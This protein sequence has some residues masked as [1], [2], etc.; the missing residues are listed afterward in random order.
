VYAFSHSL[1]T[2]AAFNL[3]MGAIF[4]GVNLSLF[5][6]LLDTTP[7]TNR[8]SYIAYYQTLV[9]VSAI[10]APMV[11]VALLNAVDFKWAFLVSALLRMTGSLAFLLVDR[12]E[13]RRA[14]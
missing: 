3:F 14:A 11:G 2:V 10:V 7:E 8:T 13:K 5:N 1:Y 4:S 6:A 9:N 12:I